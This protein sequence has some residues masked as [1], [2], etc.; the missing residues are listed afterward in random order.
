MQTH[1][2]GCQHPQLPDCL[3]HFFMQT[4]LVA[5]T[6]GPFWLRSVGCEI[7]SLLLHVRTVVCP[8]NAT[9]PYSA[10]SSMTTLAWHGASFQRTKLTRHMQRVHPHSMY[11]PSLGLCR[12]LVGTPIG[13]SMTALCPKHDTS[14]LYVVTVLFAQ[15]AMKF[16]NFS[17]LS[18]SLSAA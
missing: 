4:C 1:V 13:F 17:L 12:W 15:R 14:L 6:A 2:D 5:T 9:F 7:K 16:K 11:R 3:M 10:D 18:L 8:F